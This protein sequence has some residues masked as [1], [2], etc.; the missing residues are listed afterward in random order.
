MSAYFIGLMAGTSLDGVDAVLAEIS[1]PP[2]SVALRAKHYAP[3]EPSLRRRLE[4]HCFS[5]RIASAELG[6]LDAELGELFGRC[7]LDL[8]KKTRVPP[9][10]VRAIGSHG[11][12]F[13]HHPSVPYPYTLQI[14]DP[15]R[16]AEI[17]GITT[18]ADFRR[19][20]MAAGG[21]GAPLV[22]AF[23]RAVFHSPQE[24]RAVLNL[25]GI[26]NLTFLPA[27]PAVPVTGFDTGPG[28]TLMDHWIGR[29][30]GVSWD[31]DGR[32]ARQGRPIPE[33][34]RA[35]V[36]DPYF[37]RPPPKSTGPEY[38]SPAWLEKRLQA[39]PD[40]A[41]EDVQAT[42]AH[43]TA[44]GI[45]E[46]IRQAATWPARL[47]VC[48]GGAHNRYLLEILEN[49]AGCPVE[50]TAADGIDPD[51]VEAAAFAWLAW[52]TLKGLTGNLPAVTGA[53]H[54]VVLGGIYPG[55]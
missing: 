21:Q 20:D 10:R 29:H 22:P 9:D 1:A 54:E 14:G 38:F 42:L 25:G 40:H 23:H 11:Q 18:V 39:F 41:P 32:W 53:R 13:H 55:T 35:L 19:R 24:D 44:A 8:L 37:S 26:A 50:T 15:N 33:L 17:T 30:R 12:T 28:N 16:I 5:D 36:D 52:R 49:Q 46:A 47:L 34:L 4:R 7:A 43:L 48:G 27:D 6:R 51:W 2:C 31:E 45:D 3:F